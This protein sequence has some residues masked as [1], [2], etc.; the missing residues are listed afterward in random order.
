[1]NNDEQ[2][3][4]NNVYKKFQTTMIGSLARFESIF[5]HLWEQDSEE[6]DKF[7][8]MWEYARNSILNNGNKQARAAVDDITDFLILKDPHKI[9]V[10][11]KI[12]YRFNTDKQQG[13]N[14]EN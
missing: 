4:I 7:A 3:L 6:G 13:D 9:L 1:M 5:G 12:N 10:K 2:Q 11:N 14:D 8:D